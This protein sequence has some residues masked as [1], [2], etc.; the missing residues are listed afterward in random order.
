VRVR[1]SRLALCAVLASA[2]AAAQEAVFADD[3]TAGLSLPGAP[4]AGEHDATATV[5]NPAGL[6]FLGGGHLELA[7]TGHR[8]D[9]VTAGG[10]G[11][12]VYAGAPLD[13][14]FL[15]RLGFGVAI[16]KLY[17]PTEVLAPDPGRPL[18]LSL[19]AAW[20]VGGWL[21]IGAA[22]RRFYGEGSG[23]L[24]GVSTL[25]VGLAARLGNHV[26]VGLVGRDLLPPEVDGVPLERR[27]DAEVVLRPLGTDRLE[28]AVA[29]A[30]GERRGGLDPRARLGVRI[31]DGLHLRAAGELRTHFELDAAGATTRRSEALASLGLEVS[32]GGVGITTYG[33]VSSGLGATRF[34]GGTVIARLSAERLP[35]I[36][37]DGDRVERVKLG[38]KMD[39]R[40]LTRALLGL[41]RYERDD[42]VRAVFLQIDGLSAGWG[43]LEEL[44]DAILRLRGRGKRVIA[45][46]V[47]GGTRDY[48]VAC[49]ADKVYLDAGGGLR[50]LGLSSSGFYLRALFDRV[51]VQ[52][53]FEKIEEYKSAPEMFTQSGPSPEAAEQRSALLEDIHHHVVAGIAA[54]RRLPEAAVLRLFEQGPYTAAEAHELGIVDALVEP[55][56]L[57]RLLLE[58]LGDDVRLGR[59]LTDERPPAWR[60]PQIAVVYLDGDIVAG[61]SKEVPLLG[62][63]VAGGETLSAAL[64]WARRADRVRAV[65]LRVS[66]PGG[67]ALASEQIAREGFRLRG[68]KPFVISIGDVAASGGYFASAPGDVIF[69]EPSSITGSI[70]IFTGKFDLSGL[71]ARLGVSWEVVTRGPHADME[72][73][74]RPYTDEERA[75]IKDKLRYYYMRF[76]SAVAR[77]RNLSEVEVDAV[78]RG[79]V[80]TGAQAK[81][82]RLVDRHG[83]LL[84]ALAEA[85]RRAGLDDDQPVELVMLPREPPS[86]LSQ[87]LRLGGAEEEG[88]TGLEPLEPLV[89]HIP[90][91]LL[92]DPQ[93]PQA[94]LP[95]LLID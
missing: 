82:R 93:A 9:G 70:G 53:Q 49:A 10:T 92:V 95:L 71:L 73:F 20:Q 26:A 19:G 47:S 58:E 31:A 63:R 46:L 64:A 91:S 74:L 18:R 32:L 25:D 35:S 67:S 68:I 12:G 60:L 17:P 24:G 21:S 88:E 27:Y 22:W 90:A 3:P 65:I 69:A 66:S 78:G 43:T 42:G 57:D 54:G 33:T 40:K 28:L 1:S 39:D 62:Q 7:A 5:T 14:P 48:Y 72:S 85:K 16:E 4:L 34:A 15:P 94:R 6:P 38:G 50:L 84:D 29:A 55:T 83:G 80:W 52:P 45:Y 11:F 36:L 77:G 89:R 41:R 30:V 2:P 76:V 51:G 75:R 79:R 86:F 81:E 61:K 44:R 13:V 59:G 23:A 8:E 87:L 37:S 56:D